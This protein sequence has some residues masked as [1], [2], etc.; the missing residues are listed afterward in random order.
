M[1]VPVEEL[2]ESDNTSVGVI[3]RSKRGIAGMSFIAS[4][5]ALDDRHKAVALDLLEGVMGG[6]VEVNLLTDAIRRGSLD[7]PPAT[8]GIALCAGDQ[9]GIELIE[10]LPINRL[11]AERDHQVAASEGGRGETKDQSDSGES[12]HFFFTLG[13]GQRME[14][15]LGHRRGGFPHRGTQSCLH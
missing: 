1:L 6:E 2:A 12:F 15:Q 5:I 10:S 4:T 7:A 11:I 3:A 8:D 13:L 14:R 9:E